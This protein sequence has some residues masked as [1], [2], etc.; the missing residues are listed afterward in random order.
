MKIWKYTLK[1]TDTQQIS[2]PIGAKALTV[3]WQ[4]GMMCLWALCNELNNKENREIL[5]CGT[6]ND[7]PVIKGDYVGTFQMSEGKLIFHV[8]IV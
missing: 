6:G 7:Y 2:M 5:I 1:L 8:F 4:N 3:Q